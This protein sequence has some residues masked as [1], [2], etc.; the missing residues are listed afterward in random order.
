MTRLKVALRAA[1][2]AADVRALG[3]ALKHNTV[4][5][6]LELAS[7]PLETFEAEDMRLLAEGVHAH[8][9]FETVTLDG[10]T[11]P[12]QLMRGPA[13]AASI[14]LTSHELGVLS[15][16]AVGAV[17]RDNT[18]LKSLRLAKNKLRASGACPIVEALEKAP[19]KV[20]ELGQN[21]L[22]LRDNGGQRITV[23]SMAAGSVLAAAAAGRASSAGG[24]D[25]D[26]APPE[27]PLQ[28]LFIA[29][30]SGCRGLEP[31]TPGF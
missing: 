1:E 10:K 23:A 15:G 14:D 29:I 30:S 5:Q 13:A 6:D 25:A 17:L 24:A 9:S 12:I 22:G 16:T 18:L 8:D 11:V 20:L 19:L 7:A 26:E 31:R 2:R 28:A 3:V 4:L 27:T 21:G